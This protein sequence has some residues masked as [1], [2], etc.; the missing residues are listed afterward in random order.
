MSVCWNTI[1]SIRWFILTH[2]FPH[3]FYPW[4]WITWQSGWWSII[5]HNT[6]CLFLDLDHRRYTSC[7][8]VTWEIPLTI[9]QCQKCYFTSSNSQKLWNNTPNAGQ[10]PARALTTTCW[11]R[12]ATACQ[13]IATTC[14]STDNILPEH[15][16][17]PARVLATD[18]GKN[19]NNYQCS[20]LITA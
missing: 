16:Q 3:G 12:G 10:Q 6:C 2:L 5:V 19:G 8:T 1:C 11:S 18:D 9:V 13:S 14:Q 4:M 17:H 7:Q 15:W 20:G